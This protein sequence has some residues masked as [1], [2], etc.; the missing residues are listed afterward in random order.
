MPTTYGRIRRRVVPQTKSGTVKQGFYNPAI[1]VNGVPTGNYAP[2]ELTVQNFN[3]NSAP[4]KFV[5]ITGDEIHSG[6]PYITGGPFATLKCTYM[7]PFG[8]SGRGVYV[9]SDRMQRYVGG[10]SVPSSTRFG[11]PSLSD[12]NTILN[13]GSIIFPSMDGWGTQAWA[14]AKP[15]LERGSAAVFIAE[16]RD[17]PRMLKTSAEG[18]HVLWRTLGGS[19]TA[20][21]MQPKKIADNFLNHQFGWVPFVSDLQRFH[22]AYVD[23][24]K[25]LSDMTARND[26]W[27]RRK[28]T[29]KTETTSIKADSGVGCIVSPNFTVASG[30]CTSNPTWELYVDTETTISAVGRF[31]YYRPEFD[32]SL[33]EYHSAW[34]AAMRRLTLYGARI[35]PSNIY[36]ATPWTWAIDWVSSLNSYVDY[37]NDIIVDSLAAKYLYLLQSQVIRR[38][39]RQVLP[40]YAGNVTLEWTRTFETKQRQEAGSPY[41]FNLTW[42]QLSPRQLAIAGA[43]AIS[44]W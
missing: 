40:T 38:R 11:G 15:H 25:L 32:Q 6:P 42:D 37:A 12:L 31:K 9:R 35:S 1:T 34:M 26:K 30:Y 21:I 2:N 23:Q 5:Q 44:R 41:G 19:G 17:T 18:F 27:T 13:M 14:K 16:F 8:V 24:A 20:K 39:I 29:L 28:V 43:L 36:K 4:W 7:D 10:F 22:A 33:T 3:Y